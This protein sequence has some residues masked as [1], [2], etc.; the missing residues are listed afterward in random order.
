M[1][2]PAVRARVAQAGQVGL[3]ASSGARPL[4]P[5][6]AACTGERA[7]PAR[8]AATCVP[9]PVVAMCPTAA[10][11]SGCSVPGLMK[12]LN[13][14]LEKPSVCISCGG[15]AGKEGGWRGG[16]GGERTAALRSLVCSHRAR[17]A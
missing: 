5:T 13:S 14:A 11:P 2:A 6:L 8:A 16:G 17:A 12:A 9:L 7:A 3:W 10:A 1:R 15:E 4:G